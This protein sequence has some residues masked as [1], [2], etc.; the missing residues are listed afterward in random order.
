LDSDLFRAWIDA[1]RRNDFER[2]WE[3]SDRSLREYRDCD[4][5]RHAKERHL[6]C[7]WRGESLENK[8]VLIRCYHGLGD[9]IQFIRFAKPLREIAR[10]VI[11][12]VQ[13]S[14]LALLRGVDGIDHLVPLHDG[15]PN[16]DFD[17]DIEIMELAHALRVTPQ[18][19]SSRVPYLLRGRSE[20]P[21]HLPSPLSIGLVWE[22]GGWDRARSVPAGLLMGLAE[23]TDV[24]LLSLQQ[25]PARLMAPRIPAKDVAVPRIEVL[26]ARIMALDLVITVD[27]MVAHLAGA[28]GAPV[29]TMLHRNCD[30]RWPLIGPE[31]IWYPTMRL[32]HQK[33]AADW[34]DVIE[35]MIVELKAFG[36][37][38]RPSAASGAQATSNQD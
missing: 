38:S 33:R 17:V 19:A 35:E 16:V 3:I 18:L 26:A 36:R 4:V 21:H 10:Q 13:P 30:W 31:T 25:G 8:R 11:V 1:L 34:T 29:W 37:R 27:T 28:L 5:A 7:V 32:F 9:T 15:T 14:L 2:A 23:K 6:Q 12:W 22:A 20:T 24:R